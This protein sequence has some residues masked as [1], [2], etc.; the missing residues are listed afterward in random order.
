MQ[1][2]FGFQAVTGL[3]L[4][5]AMSGV[6]L[7]AQLV[8]AQLA[9]AAYRVLGQPDLRQNGVNM[10]QG[11][12]LHNPNAVATD[13][14]DGAVRLYIA[15]TRNHR[16]VAWPDV[17]T[18]QNGDPPAIILGQPNPQSAG[19]LGIGAKGFNGPVAMAVD[20]AN[21]NLYVSDSNNHRVLRFPSPFANPSRVEP[22]AVYGQANFNPPANA[23]APSRGSLNRPRGL[24]FD[25][26]GNLWIADAGNH[27]IVRYNAAVLDAANPEADLVVGQRDFTSGAANRGL[28]AAGVSGSGFD[29][30]V[31]IVFD[32]QNNMYVSDF[33][34]ARVLRFNAPVNIDATAAG[35][36]GQPNLTTRGVAGQASASTLAGPIGLAL[37]ASNNLYVAVPNDNRV[38]V[39]NAAALLGATAREILGQVDATST[40]AN[41]ASFPYAS[42]STFS[43]VSDVKVDV[44]GNLLFAD[45]GNNRVVLFPRGARAAARVWG[46]LDFRAN[47]PNRVKPGSINAPFK[48]VIDYSQAPFALYVSD[49]NNHRVLGWRDA[50][51]FRNGDPADL[52]IGQPDFETALPNID[53]RGS[54]NPTATSLFSPR[55]IAVDAGG[56]LYVADSGN[57][58]V[59]RYPR[60]VSQFGRITPD[61]VLGQANFTSSVSAAVSASSLNAPSGLAIDPEG[62]LFVADTGNN[63]VLQF[64]AGAGTNAAA[65]RVFGQPGFHTGTASNVAS[66]QTLTSP[67]GI[68]VDAAFSLYVADSGANRVVIFPNTRDA[69]PAGAAAAIVLGQ[70]QFDSSAPGAGLT[71]L[72]LPWDV[73]LDSSGSVYVS[74]AGNN[75]VLIYPSVL[76]LPLAGASATGV[77]GQRDGTGTGANFNSAGSFATAEGLS[78]PLGIYVDRRD[79]LYVGDA[80][81]SRVVHFLKPSTVA[82][83]ASNQSG[84]PLGRGGL[85]RF[86]GVGLAEA[87]EKIESGSLRQILAGREI[88]INDEVRTPLVSVSSDLI[89]FQVPSSAPLGTARIAVR[90][91][92]TGEL[93]AGASYPVSGTSP[94]LFVNDSA[95]P[96]QG[97]ITNADGSMNSPTNAAAR[98]SVVKIFGTGQGP[99][100]PPV[101]DGE[102]ASADVSTVAVPTSDGAA[103]LSRQPSVCVAMGNTFGEVQ[104]SGLAPDKVGI[105]QLTVRIPTNLNPGNVAIRAVINGTPSN[106]VNLS[107]R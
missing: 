42:A 98:G 19:V 89:E 38:M 61:V 105:W 68:F 2:R 99:V 1:Y 82:H 39:F 9:R 41:P 63:R 104:F 60:P 15:D 22:D 24:A 93:L 57:N 16:V 50:V 71:G 66:A 94:G 80:G 25:N 54:A 31:G 30:P 87:E 84:T 46:Q 11:L 102:P 100:S 56:N 90:V 78:S 103:C 6:P 85:A 21:G 8:Q 35:V 58:R 72:R 17:R 13:F 4:L 10:V 95:A 45:P 12:E 79:T 23:P 74:D 107:V 62:N 28:G 67:Q 27:R 29:T 96:G 97:R 92:D 53:S 88:T 77:L 73:A 14:R 18:F 59:L 49:T 91:S 5:L 83:G 64:A 32:A 43:A 7:K 37:D 3:A 33:A 47:G 36:F 69:G 44:D 26:Q 75:R 40:Q 76:F 20:P 81:N 51:R 70:N 52:V 34:N 65:V 86:L 48:M 101:P 106:I 55:G